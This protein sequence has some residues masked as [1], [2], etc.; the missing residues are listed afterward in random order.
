RW[1][2]LILALGP[3][4][5]MLGYVAGNKTG[6]FCYNLFHHK[7]LALALLGTGLIYRNDMLI[8]TGIILF[9]HSS[10]DRMFGYGL[11][12]NEGFKFTHLGAIGKK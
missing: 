8:C 4:I 11:K 6:A 10:M 12:T 5:S 3:D 7:G 2:Y 9:G 1:Y